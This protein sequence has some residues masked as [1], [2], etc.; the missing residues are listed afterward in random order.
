MTATRVLGELY[1]GDWQDALTFEGE[2][3]CVLEG[4]VN[5]PG[6]TRQIPILE[7]NHTGAV[8]TRRRLDLAA[9]FI[10][11]RIKTNTKLLVHCAAGIERSPLAVAWWLVKDGHMPD[12]ETA[13]KYLQ[14]VLPIVGD[15]RHWIEAET[16]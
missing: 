4:S 9:D 8:A 15:R 12:L 1:V 6:M 10:T 5:Y 11:E 7:I 3:L 14:L 16:K 2:R 13:Y